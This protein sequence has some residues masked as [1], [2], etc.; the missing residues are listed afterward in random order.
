MRLIRPLIALSALVLLVPAAGCS[1]QVTGVPRTSSETAPL[2]VSEDGFGIVVGYDDAPAKIE[3]YTEPQ[4]THCAD[5]QRDFGDELAYNITV[6]TL[7]VT[8]RPLTFLDDED[9]GYSAIVANALFLATEAIDNSSATGTQFQRFVEELWF[10]QDPGGEPF[11]GDE[12]REMAGGAG[13]PDLVAN[14]VADHKEAV[15]VLDMEDTNF[16]LLYDVDP[17]DTG[18]PTVFDLNAGEKLDI[19]DEN[20]LSDLL[21]S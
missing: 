20:W 21:Q 12:L 1:R 17:I 6:G 18:T 3:I 19:F 7:Q 16:G 14:N 4:C 15:D 5:L 11:S 2:A 10:N 9:D 13:L 8:Y